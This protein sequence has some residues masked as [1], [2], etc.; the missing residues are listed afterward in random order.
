VPLGGEIGQHWMPRHVAGTFRCATSLHNMTSDTA[1]KPNAPAKK[2]ERE[3]AIEYLKESIKPDDTIYVILRHVSKSGMSRLLDLYLIKDGRPFRIT[4]NA[5][6]AL[7][8]PYDRRREALR[9]GGYGTDVAFEAAYH[10]G[11][12]I[13]NDAS[14][15]KHQWI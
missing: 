9:I 6:R 3:E 10:L 14:A 1:Q 7:E 4:W 5:A 15:L 13:F 11:W 12:A 2:S 8:V